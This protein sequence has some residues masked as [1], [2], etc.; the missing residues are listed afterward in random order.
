MPPIYG[1]LPFPMIAGPFSIHSPT[2]QQNQQ[3]HMGL[4]IE[5][6]NVDNVCSHP[7]SLLSYLPREVI[8]STM[9]RILSVP[10]CRFRKALE[11]MRRVGAYENCSLERVI[12]P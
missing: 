12:V 8:D 10:Y 9:H 4:L 7:V 2:A 5:A 11:S 6:K 1:A 3:K